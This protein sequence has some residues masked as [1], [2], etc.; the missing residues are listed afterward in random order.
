MT[1][2]LLE[3]N[4]KVYIIACILTVIYKYIHKIDWKVR[5]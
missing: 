4:I 3:E 1:N 5:L 2:T